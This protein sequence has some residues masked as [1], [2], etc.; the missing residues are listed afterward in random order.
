MVDTAGAEAKLSRKEREHMFRID[1]VLDA[2]EQVF[3]EYSFADSSVEDIARRAEL[4][5]G[6]LY[7]LFRSKEE[8]YMSVVSRSVS[9]FFEE[10]SERVAGARGPQEQLR[11]TVRYFFEHFTHYSR[12]FRLYVSATNGFQWELKNKLVGDA[13]AAQQGFFLTLVDACQRGLD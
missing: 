6:T 3:G 5:V 7:N 12:Q 8:I 10:L 13:A 9:G 1:L 4:S 2:A 11:T